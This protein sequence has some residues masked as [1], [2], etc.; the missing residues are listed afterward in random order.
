[1]ADIS[2]IQLPSGTTYDVKDK[3]SLYAG[4]AENGGTANKTAA[5][6]FAVVD[7]TSTKTAFTATVD[8]ITELV[9]GTCVLLK[10]SVVTSASGFTININGLGAKQAYSNMGT[11]YTGTAPSAETTIFNINYTMLFVYS[12]TIVSGGGWI[13]YRGYNSDTTTARGLV[14]YYFR[15]YAGQAIY[16]YKLVM[17]GADNRMYPIVVTNQE[18]ATQVAK[19]PTTV[20]LRPHNIWYYNSTSTVA[21]GAVCGSQTLHDDMYFTTAVYNFNTSTGTYRMVYL[22]GDYNKDTDMFTLYNDGSSPCTSYYAFVPSNTANITLSSYFTSGKYYILVGGTYSTTNYMTL[23]TYNPLYY[24]D[25]TNLI[26]V[27]TKITKDVQSSIPT[28]TSDLTN[29]SGYITES[30]LPEGV[31]FVDI[32]TTNNNAVTPTASEIVAAY[33]DGKQLVIRIKDF[34]YESGAHTTYMYALP[35][36]VDL[37]VQNFFNIRCIV[38]TMGGDGYY[39]DQ[40]D[41]AYDYSQ[42]EFNVEYSLDKLL[43]EPPSASAGQVLTYSGSSWGAS[44]A[45]VQSVN[46]QTGAV[47][48]SI[49]SKVS[50]LTNDSGFITTETDPTVPSWAKQSSKPS[51]TA[52]EVGA[53]PTSSVG[54]AS[55]VVP[56]NASSKIDS[57]YL[58]SYV[59]DVIEGYYYNNKFYKESSHTTEITGE[60]GKIYI[61]LSTDKTYRWGGSAYAEISQGSVISV[62]RDLTS[63]TKVGTITVNGTGTDLY[64]PS[65][66]D[67]KVKSALVSNPTTVYYPVFGNATTSAETKLYDTNFKYQSASNTS[68]LTL[69]STSDKSGQLQLCRGTTYV[70]ITPTTLTGARTLYLPDK[71]GTVAVTSDIPTVPSAGTTATAVS[72]TSSG[73]SATTWSKSDHVHSITSSTITSALGFTPYNSTNPNNYVDA[74]GAASAAPVQSVNGQTGAVTVVEDD[75]TWNGVTLNKSGTISAANMYLAARTEIDATTA[76]QIKATTTPESGKIPLYQSGAYLAS[77]TPS[78]N[79]NSTK[80]A[81]T[82]YVDAAIPTNVSSLT[83]D[84]G[85]LTLATLPIYDGTVVTNANGVSF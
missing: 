61:D 69:G 1:M 43:L 12:E 6:P 46:G 10:N 62:S 78:A 28:K 66:T 22:C 19:V 74:T 24:F 39:V 77:T 27:E 41:I 7:S 2:K 48:I 35:S 37:E 80:V 9:D 3:T 67:E 38:G 75:K 81:T 84:S 33:N 14:D 60:A 36:E 64:A 47:S 4:S 26:P 30:E 31:F 56:L 17:Q 51:Y 29:D 79:D 11:G 53:V 21:A 25:G 85:Y 82:A 16:R 32:D 72:T 5:I 18:S 55:G 8:G 34:Y 44:A 45:P 50:D 40:W 76:Y 73:G 54:A 83:N 70:A 15:A 20:G 65:N 58:P 49:P 52:N 57:T 13:A 71:G 23:F 59:D 42:D 63:G 68:Y